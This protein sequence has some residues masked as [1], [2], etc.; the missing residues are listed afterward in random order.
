MVGQPSHHCTQPFG[1]VVGDQTRVELVDVQGATT[2]EL[3]FARPFSPDVTTSI[4][5]L[6]PSPPGRSCSPGLAP[7]VLASDVTAMT[8]VPA[9]P[10]MLV[11]N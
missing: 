1:I 2:A 3:D 5:A 7:A 6:G 11:L 4:G 10:T 9:A 8:A